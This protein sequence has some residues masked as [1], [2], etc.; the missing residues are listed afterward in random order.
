MRLIVCGARFSYKPM[1]LL[2][3]R[4]TPSFPEASRI[5]LVNAKTAN[6]KTTSSFINTMQTLTRFITPF[7]FSLGVVAAETG[8]QPA[9]STLS[10]QVYNADSGSF[11]VNAVLVSGKTDAVLLD[12]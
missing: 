9:P 8:A 6:V 4:S 10:L 12:T 5:S 3:Q 2:R 1:Q 7:G 11:H